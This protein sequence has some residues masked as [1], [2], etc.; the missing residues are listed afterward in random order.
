MVAVCAANFLGNFINGSVLSLTEG[1]AIATLIVLAGFYVLSN[2]LSNAKLNVWVK[3]EIVQVGVSIAS[4]VLL[5]TMFNMFCAIDVNSLRPLLGQPSAPAANIFDASQTY[6]QSAVLYSHNTMSV[7]RYFGS[8]YTILSYR[9][10]YKCDFWCLFGFSGITS[11]PLANFG[12]KAATMNM[13]FGTSILY[14]LTALNMLM[15]L[16][17]TF[18]GM[19]LFFLPLAIVIRS[20]P[21]MRSF[22]S[23]LLAVCLSFFLVYPLLLSF[24][25]FVADG[26]GLLSDSNNMFGKYGPKAEEATF[27]EASNEFFYASVFGAFGTNEYTNNDE[28]INYFFSSSD[29]E[30]Q[31]F[32]Y[33]FAL[34]SHSFVAALLLPSLALVGALASVRFFA[35]IYGEEID[36]SRLSQMV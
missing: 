26:S 12:G 28:L 17:M 1:A 2:F 13:L 20:L 11:R 10:E 5:I 18:K 9:G 21:Y 3:T 4:V 29:Q 30:K 32:Y 24:F 19:V 6:L 15:I 27:K 8:A 25:G 23:L 16:L 36:L 7:V 22:G 34:L 14:F 31:D 33:V 35:R